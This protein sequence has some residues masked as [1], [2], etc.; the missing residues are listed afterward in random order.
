M[1]FT[2]VNNRAANRFEVDLDGKVAI[3]EYAETDAAIDLLH[4]EVPPALEGHGVG[5][6]LAAAALEYAKASGKRVVPT[7]PFVRSYI[8]RHPDWKSIVAPTR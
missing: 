2:V 5:G 8:E 4:T 7:C 1:S 3:L 6:A